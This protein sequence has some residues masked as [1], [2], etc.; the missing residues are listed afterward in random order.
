MQPDGASLKKN[1]N[2]SKFINVPERRTCRYDSRYTSEVIGGLYTD[3][4][5]ECNV[6]IL[7]KNSGQGVRISMT[8][9]DRLVRPIQIQKELEWIGEDSKLIIVAKKNGAAASIRNQALGDLLPKFGVRF[10]EPTTFAVSCDVHGSLVYH[11]RENVPP[12]AT[13]PLEWKFQSI[14]ILNLLFMD[15]KPKRKKIEGSLFA[16]ELPRYAELENASLLFDGATGQ[17][18]LQHDLKLMVLAEEFVQFVKTKTSQENSYSKTKT[19]IIVRN[20]L[21]SKSIPRASES[22][23]Q[24]LLSHVLLLV[25]E[26]NYQKIF[27]DELQ[28]MLSEMFKMKVDKSEL[29]FMCTLI[30]STQDNFE[31]FSQHMICVGQLQTPS[32][33]SCLKGIYKLCMR[34]KQHDAG[35]QDMA[36]STRKQLNL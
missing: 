32:L 17:S 4:F 7:F 35:M 9:A 21:K 31:N 13:Y 8:H 26:N 5:S 25:T 11:T 23:E 18:L 34:F 20:F 14:F 3:A 33:T 29:R 6:V 22:D 30:K 19:T 16:H 2:A 15:Y 28:F 10:C 27:N 12:L 1:A 24:L 36:C